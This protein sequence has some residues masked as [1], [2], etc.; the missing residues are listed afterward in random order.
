MERQPEDEA[1]VGH[2]PIAPAPA[3][4]QLGG[5]GAEDLLA[6]PVELAQAAEP[7]RPGDV[8]DR[9]IGVV[10]EPPGEVRA[11]A[12]SQTVG[13]GADVLGEQP[14]Q[15]TGRDAEPPGEVVLGAAVERALADQVH[16]PAHQLGAGHR[17]GGAAIRPAAQACP[18]P[19][20]LRRRR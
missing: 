15:V 17:R 5:R 16:R 13:R 19:G 2:E 8:G 20:R 9:E 1:A 14:P 12:A 10:E 11:V 4:A 18:E 6:G 3:G 7:A